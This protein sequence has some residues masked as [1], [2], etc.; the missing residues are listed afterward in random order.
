MNSLPNF[1]SRQPVYLR[2]PFLQTLL[3]SKDTLFK[4][5]TGHVIDLVSNDVQ[6]LEGGAIKLF[7]SG[8]FTFI[9]IMVVSMSLTSLFGWPSV[10][11]VIVFGVLLPFYI[12]LS[13]VGA[14]LRTRTAAVT[15]QRLSLMNQVVSGIRVIKSHA[16]EDEY[17][18][19][20]K[21][22]RR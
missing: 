18:K 11:G 21:T 14:R 19:Q 10:M 22:T 17:R 5:S 6:R 15:D 13:F 3:L 9:E 4:F 12:V 8:S 1:V 7:F 16:W 20:I 2:I